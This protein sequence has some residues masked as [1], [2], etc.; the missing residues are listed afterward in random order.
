VACSTTANTRIAVKNLGIAILA[1]FALV[2][3]ALA[4]T[5]GL[6]PLA[7]ALMLAGTG[8]VMSAVVVC[9]GRTRND[10]FLEKCGWVAALVCTVLFALFVVLLSM[11]R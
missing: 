9:V 5:P 7:R 4:L 3:F 11:I 6:V 1:L 8:M 10:V 2:C